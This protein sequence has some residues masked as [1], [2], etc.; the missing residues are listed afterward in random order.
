[1]RLGALGASVLLLVSVRGGLSQPEQPRYIE[2]EGTVTDAV[3]SPIAGGE[4]HFTPSRGGLGHSKKPFS[5]GQYRM[6]IPV[7]PKKTLPIMFKLTY[8]ADDKYKL[9]PHWVEFLSPRVPPGDK[10]RIHVVLYTDE[11]L[12]HASLATLLSEGQQLEKSVLGW[13]EAK[14]EF[15]GMYGRHF[16]L[17][18][19]E[20]R[21]DAIYMSWEQA[22]ARAESVPRAF[23]EHL[24]DRF[25]RDSALAAE[26]K[27]VLP[28]K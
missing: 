13:M 8:Y 4:V 15:K 3:G 28:A 6:S 27:K 14:E 24:R 17:P 23:S 1:M 18:V 2:I 22:A 5:G 20:K 12:K 21:R 10:H 9:P 25:S 19:L 26:M 11:Q 16:S 7:P